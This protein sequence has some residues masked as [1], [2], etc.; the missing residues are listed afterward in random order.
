M[1]ADIKT[2]Q[3]RDVFATNVVVTSTAQNTIGV[4]DSFPLPLELV[5][6][7]FESLAA[8]FKIEPVKQAC[9]P[10]L[11]TSPSLPKPRRF[12]WP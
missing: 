4:Q 6:K 9:S 11:S 2:I 1:Q 10:M 12:D 5:T 3:E 7:Q 8:D